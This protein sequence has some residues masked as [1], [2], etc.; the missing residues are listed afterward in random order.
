MVTI[1]QI[2]FNYYYTF[3]LPNLPADVPRELKF[4]SSV[5]STMVQEA[6]RL[7]SV[8]PVTVTLLFKKC[9]YSP[10]LTLCVFTFTVSSDSWFSL[11][12]SSSWYCKSL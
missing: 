8:A 5:C 2:L 7:I 3:S 11:K 4:P 12:S 9:T 10:V 1:K 6:S